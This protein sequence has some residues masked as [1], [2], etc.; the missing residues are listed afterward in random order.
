[1]ETHGE[2][3][4][5]VY[6]ERDRCVGHAQCFAVDEHLFPVDDNG[7]STVESFYVRAGDED[8]ARRGV[9]TCPEH[10]LV[11]GEEVEQAEGP[12]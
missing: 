11:I 2:K 1:M 3:A 9:D 4:M 5:T 10:A 8:S 12:N 6:L 7:Y